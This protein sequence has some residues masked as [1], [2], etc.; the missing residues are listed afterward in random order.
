MADDASQKL[1]DGIGFGKRVGSADDHEIGKRC[2]Y[3][4]VEAQK[5]GGLG[6]ERGQPVMEP[7][8][9]YYPRLLLGRSLAGLDARD[10]QSL[11]R[12]VHPRSALMLAA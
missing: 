6:I 4:G 3:D 5:H 12:H 11:A 2:H 10:R 1:D 7:I 8:P 9:R